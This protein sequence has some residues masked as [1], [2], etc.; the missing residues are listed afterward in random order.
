MGVSQKNGRITFDGQLNDKVRRLI[1][2]KRLHLGL[3]YRALAAYFHSSWSTIRKWE[4]GPTRSCSLSQRPRLEAFL[5]G[6]CDAEL[7]QQVTMPVPAYKMNFP[8]PVQ[9]CMERMGTI[10][11]LLYT[12]PELLDRMLNDIEQVSQTI[13]QQLVNDE[14]SKQ[15]V[16]R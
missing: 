2:E 10:L 12:R 14:S 7:L 8:E 11:S 9:C 1:R 4:Y 3:T 13:L 6:D 16:V 15:D 5:N